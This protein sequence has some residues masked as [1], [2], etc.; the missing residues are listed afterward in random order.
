MAGVLGVASIRHAP[1]LVDRSSVGTTFYGTSSAVLLPT[2]TVRGWASRASSRSALWPASPEPSR[3]A[4]VS[5]SLLLLAWSFRG[6][7]GV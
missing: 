6:W 2:G 3:L 5:F 1:E 7:V 4:F